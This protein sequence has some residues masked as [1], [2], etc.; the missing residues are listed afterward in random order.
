MMKLAEQ[1]PVAAKWPK[2]NFK[3]ALKA[4]IPPIETV[5]SQYAKPSLRKSFIPSVSQS[6]LFKGSFFNL[7]FLFLSISDCF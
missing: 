7:Y 1:P 5:I 2:F 4:V 3:S 6:F